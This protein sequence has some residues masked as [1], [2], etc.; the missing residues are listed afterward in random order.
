MVEN[1]SIIDITADVE[2]YFSTGI[3]FI[4]KCLCG[5]EFKNQEF[6]ISDNPNSPYS[7]PECGA[8]IFYIKTIKIF[9]LG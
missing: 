8:K 7:C 6:Y 2:Y 5:A 9:K 3:M 4:T 1:K